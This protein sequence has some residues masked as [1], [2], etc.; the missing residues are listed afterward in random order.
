VRSALGPNYGISGQVAAVAGQARVI[1]PQR[2]TLAVPVAVHG[3][4][5]YQIDRSAF[6]ALARRV[7]GKN[8]T[9]ARAI[10]LRV[11]GVVQADIQLPDWNASNLPA[12]S[13]QI[14]IVVVPP[15][16]PDSTPCAGW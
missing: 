15:K 11:P 12:D 8:P 14:E 9:T 5:I 6:Q 16:G 2:G 3:W 10:L 13:N 4:W 7:A 1:D